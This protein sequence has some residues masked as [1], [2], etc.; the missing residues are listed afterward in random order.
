MKKFVKR[1]AAAMLV[2]IMAFSISA[3]S[4]DDAASGV[5]N[6]V[7]RVEILFNGGS[8]KTFWESRVQEFNSTIGKEKNIEIVLDT[9]VDANYNQAIEVA[10]QSDQLP[11]MFSYGP[12]KQM[13]ELDVIVPL[14]ELNGT[15][16]MIERTKDYMVEEMH[17][18]GDKVYSYPSGMT[19]RGL[20]YNKDMFKAAGLVDENGEAKPP[21]TYDEMVE[22][23]KILTDASKMQYGIIFPVK[24]T[25]WVL[26]D[27]LD[28]SAPSAGNDGYNPVT[29]KYDYTVAQ[30]LIDAILKIKNDGSCYPGAEGM[31]N[32]PAR[33][34]FSEGQIGMKFAYSFDVGVFNDQ[35]Q[36]KCDWG[37]APL[38]VADKDN[39]YK[40]YAT[41]GSSLRVSRR[42][43]ERHGVDIM[44]TVYN[45]WCSDEMVT[46]LYKQGYSIPYDWEIVKDV[47]LTDAKK[48]WKEF[49]ALASIST[50]SPLQMPTNMDGLEKIEETI[51]NEVWTGKSGI[52]AL[53]RCSDVKN[54]GIEEYQKLNPGRDYSIY[55]DENWNSKR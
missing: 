32:D 42:A 39:K 18:V 53:E 47:E 44:S 3:C 2:G 40:Q 22:Y 5:K 11:D 12:L 51:V 13:S 7:H 17:K 36:A 45:W 25:S 4:G 6:G 33:A 21:E 15:E 24:W 31:D 37:V 52:E 50:V 48:N 38:P 27:V 19:L 49:C 10:M 43:I 16:E 9:K 34:K 54:K 55:I 23:A 41:V 1:A 20:V 14:D 46:E 28:A 8:S 30:P 26:S 35:F 29:G